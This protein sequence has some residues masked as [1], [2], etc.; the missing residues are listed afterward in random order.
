MRFQSDI[1]VP[2]WYAISYDHN[3]PKERHSSRN[4]YVGLSLQLDTVLN[5]IGIMPSTT[6][7]VFGYWRA[8]KVSESRPTAAVEGAQK[9]CSVFNI[10]VGFYKRFHLNRK[11]NLIGIKTSYLPLRKIIKPHG[12]FFELWQRLDEFHLTWWSWKPVHVD[13]HLD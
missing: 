6:G 12:T 10:P 7:K 5:G 3:V 1:L 9:I 2:N 13:D 4:A 8:T 11:K